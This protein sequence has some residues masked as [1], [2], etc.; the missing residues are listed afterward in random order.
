MQIYVLPTED[1]LKKKKNNLAVPSKTR[2]VL[3]VI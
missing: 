3:K 1:N 2:V